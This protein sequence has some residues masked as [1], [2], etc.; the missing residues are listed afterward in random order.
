[1]R[2]KAG[3]LTAVGVAAALLLA[4]TPL[5]GSAA[6]TSS[7][8]LCE[9]TLEGASAGSGIPNGRFFSTGVG[10]ISASASTK[11]CQVSTGSTIETIDGSCVINGKTLDPCVITG[12][13]TTVTALTTNCSLVALA[14]GSTQSTPGL[15]IALTTSGPFNGCGSGLEAFPFS[16]EAAAYLIGVSGVAQIPGAATCPIAGAGGTA[17]CTTVS[18]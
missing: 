5:A 11:D 1:M 2:T 10:T 15:A 13:N 3:N 18:Q 7:A 16:K 12:N 9:G 17:R 8:A 14:E 6:A 4:L